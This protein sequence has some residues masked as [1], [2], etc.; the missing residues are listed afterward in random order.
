MQLFKKEQINKKNSHGD[1]FKYFMYN[2]MDISHQKGAT[3]QEKK[4]NYY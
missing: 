1:I 4:C 3:I 2:Y